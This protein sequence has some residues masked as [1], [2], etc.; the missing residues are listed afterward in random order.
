MEYVLNNL[1]TVIGLLIII[2]ICF[3]LVKIYKYTSTT[4]KIKRLILKYSPQQ[5]EVLN[6]H[7]FTE[8]AKIIREGKFYDYEAMD[9]CVKI[10]MRKK[11]LQ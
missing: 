1:P 7:E 4:R 9:H 3:W 5:K 8:L 10:Y 2:Y 11:I 6:D